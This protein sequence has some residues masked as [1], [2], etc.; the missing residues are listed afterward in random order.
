VKVAGK[1]EAPILRRSEAQKILRAMIE[2]RLAVA[3]PTVDFEGGVRYIKVEELAE[4][5]SK[6]V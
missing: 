2:G 5:S 1:A 3:E 4:A 6:L